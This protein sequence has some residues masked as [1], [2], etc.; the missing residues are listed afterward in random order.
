M[1]TG[2]T[3]YRD[4]QRLPVILMR[5][6]LILQVIQRRDYQRLQVIQMRDYLGDKREN[7]IL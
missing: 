2:V 4:Y 3:S 6:Y 1:C 5:N 7:L